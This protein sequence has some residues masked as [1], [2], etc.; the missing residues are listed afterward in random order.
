MIGRSK[1]SIVVE[2]FH[3]NQQSF[4]LLN[5]WLEMN[6]D[7]QYLDFNSTH[8]Q[9]PL[10]VKIGSQLVHEI[11][12][13]LLAVPLAFELIKQRPDSNVLGFQ[14]I[15]PSLLEEHTDNRHANHRKIKQVANDYVMKILKRL[16]NHQNQRSP[17]DIE[18][19]GRLQ[20]LHLLEYLRKYFSASAFSS[21]CFYIGL[22]RRL[23]HHPA[24]QVNVGV[25]D[26]FVP[27]NVQMEA[28]F[29]LQSF[30]TNFDED[31]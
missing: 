29:L 2:V 25:E 3:L 21:L 15:F 18:T 16:G 7:K 9:S 23:Y 4:A 22:Q 17:L 14:T 13:D 6:A 30:S 24:R 27:S 20:D 1:A 10:P 12:S 8:I 5:K 11:P 28:K 26:V 31:L 19:I